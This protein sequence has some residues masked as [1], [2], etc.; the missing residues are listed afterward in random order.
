MERVLD[1]K[2][3]ELVGVEPHAADTVWAESG[4]VRTMLAQKENTDINEVGWQP[5]LCVQACSP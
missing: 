4:V 3:C 2:E 5:F 1:E